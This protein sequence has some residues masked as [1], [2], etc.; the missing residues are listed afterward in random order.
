MDIG[1]ITKKLKVYSKSIGL[2]FLASLIPMVLNMLTNPMIAINM[3]PEDY[4]IIGYYSAFT[5]LLSPLIVFYLFHYYAKAY[6]ECNAEQQEKLKSTICKS[7]I[8]FSGLLS[9]LSFIGVLIYVTQDGDS[10]GLP[11][12]PYLGLTIFA[13]PLSG[14]FTFMQTD[15]RM[16]RHP[17]EFFK[18]TVINGLLLT[19]LNLLL[20]AGL[21]MGALGKTLAPFLIQL[22]FFLYCIYKYWKILQIPFDKSLFKKIIKFCMPLTLAAML[23]FFTN[24]YDRVYLERI[25]EVREYGYYVVGI[26]I[27]TYINVFQNAIGSTFKPDLF[28]AVVKNDRKRLLRVLLLLLGSISFIALAFITFCPLIIRILTADRYIESTVYAQIAAL[29]IVTSMMYYVVSEITIAKGYTLV[30][31]ANSIVG[32][33]LCIGLFYVLISK[34]QFIGAAW[35]LVGAYIVKLLGNL[36]LIPIFNRQKKHVS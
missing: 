36:M 33:I 24:G 30:T 8:W 7:L 26:Q 17:K 19:G 2:Y 13:I 18:V 1:N 9:I 4:A 16:G 11:I 22:I 32:A 3:S 12:F 25:G 34:F 35:G 28:E 20:V 5:N 21:K 29:S 15:L 31:L 23:G 27:A 6:F 14:L 10:S